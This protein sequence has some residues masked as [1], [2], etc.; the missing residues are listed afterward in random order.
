MGVSPRVSRVR[1]FWKFLPAL[2]IIL[3]IVAAII[4]VVR[5]KGQKPP[6][7]RQGSIAVK[8][9][10][11]QIMPMTEELSYNG[12]IAAIQQAIIL[13]EV[14]GALKKVLVDIGDSVKTNQLLA[15]ID[16]SVL[17]QTMISAQASYH[18]AS[19]S[20]QRSREL[21]DQKMITQSGLDTIKAAMEIAQANYELA[22]TQLSYTR[23]LAPFSGYIV[24]R[25][26][27]PGVLVVANQTR[28]LSLMDLDTVEVVINLLEKD[29]PYLPQ[30][31]RI[32][33]FADAFPDAQY[34]GT[35]ARYSQ[36]VDT[37]TRTMAVQIDV[38]NP[39]HT[40][41]PGMFATARFIIKENPEAITLPT[42]A[43]L[44]D[45]S[46]TYVYTV[47][48]N[49]AR[50]LLVHIGIEQNNRAEIISGVTAEQDIV[51]TGQQFLREGSIVNIQP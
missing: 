34:T 48:N 1:K 45:T 33:V 43:I 37:T 41:K 46:G 6:S 26:Q 18:N 44:K 36:A 21:F 35:I 28:L 31:K 24:D 13:P 49:F 39:Q 25:F 17:Y 40:L 50:K 12:N 5:K 3:I 19:A 20:Y 11:P 22:K 42:T 16:S 47:E 23:I 4:I 7:A 32:V 10:K 30:L 38:S 27:D 29:T 51:T 9:G 15:V 14:S 2:I 8:L